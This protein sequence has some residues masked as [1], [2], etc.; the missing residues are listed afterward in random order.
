MKIFEFF[1]PNTLSG[2]SDIIMVEQPDGS[3]RSSPWFLR[4][5]NMEILKHF[6]RTI[7]VS[8][9]DNPAPF[10]MYVNQWGIG[11]F[12]ATQPLHQKSQSANIIY[13]SVINPEF[14]LSPCDI[15]N[16]L[17]TDEKKK[18]TKNDFSSFI[19]RNSAVDIDSVFTHDDPDPKPIKTVSSNI[20]LSESDHFESSSEMT[21]GEDTKHP[22]PSALILQSIRP[23]LKYGRNE[24]S[25]TV[26][27]L[28]Q[29]PKTVNTLIFLYK[30]TDKLILSDI[31][32]T[33]TISDAIGQ[34]FAYIGADW[35]QPGVAKLFDQ[36]AAHGLYFLYLSSRPVSQAAVTRSLIERI[37]QNGI[38]LPDGP[39]ITSNDSLLGSLTREIVIRCPETFKIP[40]IGTLIDLWPKNEN[41]IVLALGNKQNDVRSYAA[42]NIDHKNIILFDM[43]H[44]VLDSSGKLMFDSIKTFS[45]KLDEILKQLNII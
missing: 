23:F 45:T 4:F 28:L 17:T 13:P 18:D 24:I 32:G 44:R 43:R 27:S 16:I 12:Y 36:M 37:N 26:S 29:G 6:T 40:I 15:R 1:N 39:C 20:D 7:S 22:I 5:G 2:A 41:P 19:L 14:S 34:A 10:T 38:R 3:L 25:F 33:I 30:H 42:N 11:Q 9:N 8:I 35:S 21:T 31:D